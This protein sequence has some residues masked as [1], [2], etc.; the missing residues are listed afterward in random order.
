MFARPWHVA[1]LALSAWLA[2]MGVLQAQ[3]HIPPRKAKRGRGSFRTSIR[4]CS[5]FKQR[6]GEKS[7][8]PFLS[9]VVW[10]RIEVW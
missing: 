3:P 9:G 6:W 1:L 2:W 4:S 8:I 5:V 7:R 10:S